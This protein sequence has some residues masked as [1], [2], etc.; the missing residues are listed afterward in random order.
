[1]RSRLSNDKGVT[2]V[3]L[4]VVSA[5]VGLVMVSVY[6]LY[7]HSHRT[8]HTSESVVV[9]QQN[10][11]VALDSL[12]SDMRMAGFLVPSS[13]GPLEDI[14]STLVDD[15]LLTLNLPVSTG[16]YARA[17][18][19]A[20]IPAGESSLVTVSNQMGGGFYT[21]DDVIA[22]NPLNLSSAGT[23]T[24]SGSD[25]DDL[26][27]QSGG[28]DVDIKENYLLLRTADEDTTFPLTVSYSLLEDPLDSSGNNDGVCNEGE[29]CLLQRSV[30]GGDAHT[31]ASNISSIDLEYLDQEGV[32]SSGNPEQI[33]MVR[34]TVAAK[35]EDNKIGQNKYR[36]LQTNVMLRNFR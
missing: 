6:S 26:T 5:I 21:G 9:A 15:G 12:V 32:D 8:A 33:R 25:G 19:E 3:E 7:L 13:T 34:I 28:A 29:M 22:V 18:S 17:V 27:L 1:M 10:L 2:L 11:R 35:T 24:V 20:D 30:N 36:Q 23:L 16:I 14:P 31:L 4:L